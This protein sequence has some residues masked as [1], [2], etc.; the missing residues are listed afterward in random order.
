MYKKKIK[1]CTLPLRTNS[2]QNFFP[3]AVIITT[4]QKPTALLLVAM[5]INKLHPQRPYIMGEK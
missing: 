4:V 5:A 3:L 1:T 2:P